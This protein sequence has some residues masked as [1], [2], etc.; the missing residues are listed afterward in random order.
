LNCTRNLFGGKNGLG[1]VLMEAGGVIAYTSRK[2]LP[3]MKKTRR[4]NFDG[5]KDGNLF[6][7]QLDMPAISTVTQY[8]ILFIV[9]LKMQSTDSEVL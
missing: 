6:I 9:I 5:K 8:P 7:F 1:G 2:L 4:H 3:P